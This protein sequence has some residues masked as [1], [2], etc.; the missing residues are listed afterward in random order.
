MSSEKKE[1][2]VLY[3][4]LVGIC[5]MNYSIQNFEKQFQVCDVIDILRCLCNNQFKYF[6]KIF[7]WDPSNR[8]YSRYTEKKLI[9]GQNVYTANMHI[10]L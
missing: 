3:S 4:A 10:R 1:T 6:T 8:T 5:K 9:D 2:Q 7:N